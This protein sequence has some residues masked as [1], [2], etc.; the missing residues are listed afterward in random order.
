MRRYVLL[1]AFT[2]LIP[3]TSAQ[4]VANPST[5]EPLVPIAPALSPSTRE[6]VNLSVSDAVALSLEASPELRAHKRQQAPH[7]LP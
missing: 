4:L 3:I 5:A 6:P 7:A 1:L 2:I